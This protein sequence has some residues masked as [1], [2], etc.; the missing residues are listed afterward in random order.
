LPARCPR[1]TTAI[2][3]CITAEQVD[4]LPHWHDRNRFNDRQRAVPAYA[5]GTVS[6]EGVTDAAFDARKRHFSTREIVELT[7]MAAYC[8]GSA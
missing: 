1:F 2:S 4:G 3:F 8:S 7:M 6:A 5:D